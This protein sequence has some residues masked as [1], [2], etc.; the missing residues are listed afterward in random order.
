MGVRTVLKYLFIRHHTSAETAMIL[1]I[2]NNII[3]QFFDA[4][5][6]YAMRN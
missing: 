5:F 3:I 1:V 6:K 4:D 2:E